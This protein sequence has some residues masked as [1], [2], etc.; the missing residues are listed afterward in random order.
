[1]LRIKQTN[2]SCTLSLGMQDDNPPTSLELQNSFGF[3]LDLA[4][5]SSKNACDSA[6]RQ[7]LSKRFFEDSACSTQVVYPNALCLSFNDPGTP[8]LD[9]PELSTGSSMPS[10]A[11]SSLTTPTQP[12]FVFP[13]AHMYQTPDPFPSHTFP[14]E[15]RAWCPS[16][17]NPSQIPF[18]DHLSHLHA[19]PTWH[20]VPQANA[21][22]GY[23]NDKHY[24][25][26]YGVQVPTL[27]HPTFYAGGEGMHHP[28]L[29]DSAWSGHMGMDQQ[30]S[31]GDPKDNS[32]SFVVGNGNGRCHRMSEGKTQGQYIMV[33]QDARG[34][35]I[36]NP[37]DAPSKAGPNRVK[38]SRKRQAPYEV[39]KGHKGARNQN[40]MSQQAFQ[41][42]TPGYEKVGHDD[43]ASKT[44]TKR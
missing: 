20:P 37:L 31:G 40:D 5:Q 44:T 36:H 23:A 2:P 19:P 1:M 18:P 13:P 43:K 38:R 30:A 9:V 42:E 27:P 28:L 3:P 16:I 10:S 35:N 15:E 12:L 33:F 14:S 29:N 32:N 25:D 34:P 24:E 11:T 41:S 26:V 7:N 22:N 8:D 4:G 17:A 6:H 39:D 21:Y